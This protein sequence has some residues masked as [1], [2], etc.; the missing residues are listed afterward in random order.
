MELPER[1]RKAARLRPSSPGRL[2]SRAPVWPSPRPA[3]PP[4]IS[5]GG[6]A[7]LGCLRCLLRSGRDALSPAASSPAAVCLIRGVDEFQPRVF[8]RESEKEA[9]DDDTTR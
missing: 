1:R 6:A 8:L 5:R 7:L 4:F 9:E 3:A 2:A